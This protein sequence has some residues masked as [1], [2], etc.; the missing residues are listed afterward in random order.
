MLISHS[1]KFVMIH[2]YKVAGSSIRG[3]LNPYAAI[4]WRQS[5]LKDKWIGVKNLNHKCFSSQFGGHD[6]AVDLKE[7]FPNQ[8][9]ENY[10]KFAF[11][12]N[13]WDWQVSLYMFGLKDKNH[14]QHE[15]FKSFVDFEAYLDWRI[16]EDLHLQ[17]DFVVDKEGKLLVDFIGRLENLQKDFMHI[18]KEVKV[19]TVN[20]PH[21]N[22]SN[23]RK[24]QS[25]YN[26][27]TKQK[28]A[29]AFKE[30]IEFF[31]Y[32]YDDDSTN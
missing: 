5:S 15:L 12:R 18:C 27:N 4:S 1:H 22:K 10:F 17:K 30:D 20:L 16:K 25:F 28:V 9:F 14:Y 6:K 24:Y 29:E 8:L 21:L 19:P 11:V 13:P 23:S 32:S 3:V 31:N 26:E 2:V 7:N